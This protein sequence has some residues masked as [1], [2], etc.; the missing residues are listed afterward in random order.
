MTTGLSA[1]D[2]ALVHSFRGGE[3]VTGDADNPKTNTHTLIL[4]EY[5]G[6]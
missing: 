2:A 4:T 3:E 1:P 5:C 6:T